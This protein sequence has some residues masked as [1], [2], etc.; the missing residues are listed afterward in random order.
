[1]NFSPFIEYCSKHIKGDE[2][3]E[4]QIFLDHFFMALGYEDGLKGAGADCEYR[5]R[6]EKKKTSFADLEWNPCVLIE[7][8]KVRKI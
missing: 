2:K 1:M 5:I 7:I 8:K 3:G 6:N 4:A